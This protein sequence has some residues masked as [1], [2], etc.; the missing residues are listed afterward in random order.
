MKTTCLKGAL[1]YDAMIWQSSEAVQFMMCL[2]K[3]SMELLF[4]LKDSTWAPAH[5]ARHAT[6]ANVMPLALT[7]SKGS[8]QS[9]IDSSNHLQ[10]PAPEIM[11]IIR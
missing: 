4:D 7:F 11:L 10:G 3:S 9:N 2:R 6:F 5:S 1:W 8:Q